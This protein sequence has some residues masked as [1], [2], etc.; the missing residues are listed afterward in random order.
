MP[1]Q[2]A[3]AAACAIVLTADPEA[4]AR[5]VILGEEWGE[6]VVVCVVASHADRVALAMTAEDLDREIASVQ[7]QVAEE[8]SVGIPTQDLAAAAVVEVQ[9]AEATA[10]SA[11]SADLETI[12]RPEMNLEAIPLPRRGIIT[13]RATAFPRGII[14]LPATIVLSPG[15]ITRIAGDVFPETTA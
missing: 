7:I 15:M 4:F 1:I 2:E 10:P 8:E 9:V 13:R 6:T 5:A 3:V 12:I 14:L 11:P